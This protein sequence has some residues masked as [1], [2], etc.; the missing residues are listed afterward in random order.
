[1]FNYNLIYTAITKH[2]RKTLTMKRRRPKLTVHRASIIR[3]FESIQPSLKT[4]LQKTELNRQTRQRI[5][6]IRSKRRPRQLS[7]DGDGLRRELQAVISHIN[8]N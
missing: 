8:L 1:M 4:Q 6:I 7:V 2:P 3:R 5:Y